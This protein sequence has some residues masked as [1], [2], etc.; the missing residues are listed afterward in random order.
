[1]RP[2]TLAKKVGQ[3]I[4]RHRKSVGLTQAQ[5]AEKLG[6]ENESLSRIETGARQASLS[7]LEQL[8]DLF[9]C[10]VVRFFEEDVS[11]EYQTTLQ[12]L[13]DILQTLNRE[14]RGIL[15]NFMIQTVNLFRNRS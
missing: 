7:R 15:L 11:D 14:E 10:P 12:S 4:A 3:A 8:S 13:T 9:G 5:V 2:K 1:M 6:L